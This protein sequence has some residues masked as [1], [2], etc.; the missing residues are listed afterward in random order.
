MG[1]R[2]GSSSRAGGNTATQV[3]GADGTVIDLSDSPLRYGGKDPNLKGKVRDAIEEFENARWTSQIEYSRFVGADGSVIEENKGGKKSVG[4]SL[5]A[6]L[7]AD[8]MSHVHPRWESPGEIGGTFSDGDI[9][10]FVTFAQKTYRATAAEGTYSISKGKNFNG[11]GLNAY[12][13]RIK[14][15]ASAN[16]RKRD[17]AAISQVSAGKISYSQ[18]LEQRENIFNMYLVELHNGLRAGQKQYGYYYTLERRSR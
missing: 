10:N 2:G 17:S 8:A 9:R 18:Y 13:A 3:I 12:Y 5:G 14:R 4:A 11:A 16:Y 15:T 7:S 1:G 6:R